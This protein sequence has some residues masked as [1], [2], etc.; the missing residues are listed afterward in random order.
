MYTPVNPQF[1]YMIVWCRGCTLYGHVCMMD[2]LFVFKFPIVLC[3][4]YFLQAN[5]MKNTFD[6]LHL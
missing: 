3:L 2:K 4:F 1:Y 6:G 5:I